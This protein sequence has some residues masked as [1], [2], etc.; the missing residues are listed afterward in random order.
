MILTASRGVIRELTQDPK[1]RALQG[2]ATWWIA[3][4]TATVPIDVDEDPYLGGAETATYDTFP[5]QPEVV[6][7]A[8]GYGPGASAAGHWVVSV[9]DPSPQVIDLTSLD[10]ASPFVS[11]GTSGIGMPDDIEVVVRP[12]PGLVATGPEKRRRRETE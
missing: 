1:R 9:S 11:H 6:P 4:D 7:L 3:F 5:D 12:D 10:L 2:G 8:H